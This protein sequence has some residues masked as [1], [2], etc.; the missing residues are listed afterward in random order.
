MSLPHHAVTVGATQYPT[1]QAAVAA[2][3]EQGLTNQGI[4]DCLGIS[5]GAVAVHK[6][7]ALKAAG[8]GTHNYGR[9]GEGW[10][11]RLSAEVAEELLPHAQARRCTPNEIVRR[12]VEAAIGDDMVAAILDDGVE[13]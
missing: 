1:K 7:K 3:A 10:L 12:I 4:A 2:L 6:S 9:G 8:Q 11:V 5:A 13:A